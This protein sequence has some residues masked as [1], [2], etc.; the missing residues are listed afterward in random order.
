MMRKEWWYVLGLVVLILIIAII[1][2][3]D[4]RL[5]PA[6]VKGNV[7]TESS[8]V[9]ANAELFDWVRKTFGEIEENRNTDNLL[10]KLQKAA[11]DGA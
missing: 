7:A 6:A 9:N 2:R 11:A 10:K 5:A 3:E 8:I 4:I 1:F